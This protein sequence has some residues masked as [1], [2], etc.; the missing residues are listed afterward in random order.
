MSN[1]VEIGWRTQL[2]YETLPWADDLTAAL[3]PGD[4]VLSVTTVLIDLLTGLPFP[5]GLSGSP[6][7]SGNVVQQ[8]VTGLQAGHNYRLIFNSGLGGSKVKSSV[9][10]LSTPY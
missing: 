8:Q 6:T 4:S 7:V 1:S 10:N 9:V 2:S 5:S 3:D